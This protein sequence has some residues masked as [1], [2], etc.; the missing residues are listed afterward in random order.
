[1]WYVGE[2]EVS[3]K[4]SKSFFQSYN[5]KDDIYKLKIKINV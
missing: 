3:G 2:S 5:S 4:G 1:M